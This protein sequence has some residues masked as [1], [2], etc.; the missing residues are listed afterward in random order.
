MLFLKLRTFIPENVNNIVDNMHWN[1]TPLI[2]KYT[3]TYLDLVK[4]EIY[5]EL[6]N[7]DQSN[8]DIHFEM[9]LT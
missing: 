9:S 7:L 3:L 8:K 5:I 1:I 2:L 4:F 6:L